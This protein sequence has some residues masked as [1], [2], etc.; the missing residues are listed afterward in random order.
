M[1]ALTSCDAVNWQIKL[2]GI[3]DQD[4]KI[5]QTCVGSYTQGEGVSEKL[6]YLYRRLCNAVKCLFGKKSEWQLAEEVIEKHMFSYI[7][8]PCR[9]LV[10]SKTHT[11][12]HFVAGKTL[13]F[14]IWEN[15]KKLAIPN[16]V[17]TLV[18]SQ[19]KVAQCAIHQFISQRFSA[20]DAV[21]IGLATADKLYEMGGA[22]LVQAFVKQNIQLDKEFYLSLFQ[23]AMNRMPRL[24]LQTAQETA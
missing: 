24:S 12:V 22:S 19:I 17:K 5:I 20:Y 18:E 3:K 13:S 2:V 10:K 16:F 21:M 6:T 8:S 9:E 15:E 4:A 1:G 7:P 11:Q 23:K 14:L